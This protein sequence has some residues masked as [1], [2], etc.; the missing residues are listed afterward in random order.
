MASH[1]SGLDRAGGGL[2][3]DS[4]R[5]SPRSTRARTRTPRSR[6]LE[7]V[8]GALELCSSLSMCPTASRLGEEVSGMSAFPRG[9]P[10]GRRR[11]SAR[12]RTWVDDGG[13]LPPGPRFQR[14]QPLDVVRGT[15][16]SRRGLV[17]RSR[18]ESA[19]RSDGLWNSLTMPSSD[20]RQSAAAEQKLSAQASL[21]DSS[22]PPQPAA[23]ATR[24]M[25]TTRS[26]RFARPFHAVIIHIHGQRGR[27]TPFRQRL[28]AAALREQ[29]PDRGHDLRDDRR[30][31]RS[32]GG[33][34]Q[35]HDRRVGARRPLGGDRRDPL[36]RARLRTR[37]RGQ[38][39]AGRRLGRETVSRVAGREVSSSPRPFRRPCCC[40][41]SSAS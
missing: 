29:G 40:W 12:W 22:S 3:A 5:R 20:E 38:R 1:G 6:L 16:G 32:H 13:R 26:A 19:L 34:G 37:P 4:R 41:A 10:G 15:T 31:G 24:P 25:T 30:D 27:A 2:G 8:E 33:V 21:E 35:R 28:R 9:A 36:V 7:L 23:R 14:A 39:H 18:I 11:W 17:D